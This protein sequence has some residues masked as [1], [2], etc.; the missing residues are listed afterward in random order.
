MYATF[1][2]WILHEAIP[3]F[4]DLSEAFNA[5]IDKIIASLG[6]SVQLLNYHVALARTSGRRIVNGLA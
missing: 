1:D 4:I 5:S 6:Y 3:F 2:D